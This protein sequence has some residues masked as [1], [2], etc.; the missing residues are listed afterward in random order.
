[1]PQVEAGACGIPVAA[2]DYSA[3]QDVIRFIKGYP[4]PVRTF[5]RE[6]ETNAERAYPDNQELANILIRFF[7]QSNED[8]I[9]ESM[10]VRKH[11]IE[12]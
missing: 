8:R 12:R 6:M 4:I 5:F 1:M 7:Q 3:M 2:T 9:R 10:K 11:T